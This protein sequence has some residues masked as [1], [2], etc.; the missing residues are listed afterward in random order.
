[1]LI[2]SHSHLNFE[3]FN[4]DWRQ[5]INNCLAQDI[6]ILNAGSNYQT[7]QKA[8][9]I[10]QSYNGKV[11][12][13][14]GMHPIH[15]KDNFEIKDFKGLARSEKVVAIGEIGL[16][17]FKDYGMFFE[18]QKRILLQQL[19]LAKELN[20]PVIIHCRMAH[21][22]MIEVLSGYNLP[23]VIHCFTGTWEEAEKYLNLGYYLGINGI[24]YKFDLKEVIE[25]TPLDK[26]LL[27]TDC[28]YLGANKEDRNEP[29]FVK[30]IAEDIAK[31]R[32]ISFDE[33]A[34]ATVSN[35]Q[36]LFGI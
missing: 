3:A 31:I 23:G 33:V 22:E 32:N 20:L 17:R 36:T 26:L 6:W 2:D 19:D 10:A 1:M 14:V 8:V 29:I 28:P 30:K 7:S 16:D 21:E 11:F 13:A 18:D 15:A 9:E 5:V 27:E 4:L 24:I 12:A 34:S 25:K 35:T